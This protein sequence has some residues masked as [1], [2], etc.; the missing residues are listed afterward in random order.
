MEAPRNLP[1]G[2][3]SFEFLRTNNYLYVDKTA[4]IYRLVT[5]GKPYFLSRPRRFGK[6]LLLSTIEAYFQGK[7]ELFDGLAIAG[8]EKKWMEYPVFHLDMNADK[9]RSME[10]LMNAI[11]KNLST[12]E[13]KWGKVETERSPSTRLLGLIERAHKQSGQLVV[14]LIDEYD[15]PLLDTLHDQKLNEDIRDELQGFYGALKTADKHLRFIF[16]AGI[17]KFPHVSV[18]STL[19]QLTDI[20][21]KAPYAGICGITEEELLRNFQ[22]ELH[23]LADN[24]G[25]TYEEAVTE[26]K[27]RYDGYHFAR[28][29]PDVYNPYSVLNVLNDGEYRNYWFKTGTPT[30]LVK[31]VKQHGLPASNMERDV[32]A[33]ESDI[34]EFRVGQ[35]NL[36]PFLYQSGYLTIK[37]YEKAFDTYQLGFPNQE[38]MYGF[39]E[40]LLLQYAP[41]STTPEFIPQTFL[42][43][44][45]AGDVDSFMNRIRSLFASIP[46]SKKNGGVRNEDFYQSVCFL[47]FKLL[48]QYAQIE[49]AS[50]QGRADLVVTTL[51]TVYVFEFKMMNNGTAEDA[52]KQIHEK[53]YAIPYAAGTRKVVKIGAEFSEKERTVSRW[54]IER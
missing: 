54:L 12:L 41:A 22:P 35:D 29:S 43:S 45:Y 11:D 47:L 44:L 7:K 16:L 20:S 53:G 39:Y 13:D 37:G 51:D 19:N 52:L 28:T 42:K 4:Y 36:I 25:Q 10:R 23:A 38:V 50:A 6:S 1:A 14:V 17:T 49:Q 46:Y 2:I 31:L 21:L 8:L 3:Q 24:N 18:F 30:A 5:K 9:Y 48:G 34:E 32:W 33:R 15:K 27:K 26:M 40:N